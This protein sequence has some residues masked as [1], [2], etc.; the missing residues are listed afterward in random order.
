M[1]FVEMAKQEYHSEGLPSECLI[2]NGVPM[3]HQVEGFRT[4]AV[5]GREL[6]GRTV[7]ALGR[8]GKD[9]SLFLNS[10]VEPRILTVRY[11]LKASD[12]SSFREAFN[13]MNIL[14]REEQ[15]NIRFLDELEYFY[16]GTLG[17]VTEVPYGR[18]TV[19]SELTFY[20][21]DPYKYNDPLVFE[22]ENELQLLF[23][24]FY[25]TLPHEITVTP[26]ADTATLTIRNGDKEIQLVQGSFLASQSVVISF[27]DNI[28]VTNQNGDITNTIALH[29]DLE[30]FALNKDDTVV[31]VE[32]GTIRMKVSKVML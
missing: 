21:A 10:N 4:L 23:D 19:V 32:G 9:G 2:I 18:N 20:C 5:Q 24:T 6:R 26:N 3:E 28:T 1:E 17:F 31:F 8:K 15:L 22:G 29:S 7:N 25:E 14:L 27:G 12:N 16:V 13:R 11:E 30:N